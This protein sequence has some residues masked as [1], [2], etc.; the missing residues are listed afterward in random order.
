M[1]LFSKVHFPVKHSKQARV[2]FLEELNLNIFKT[3]CI[4][5]LPGVSSISFQIMGIVSFKKHDN[6]THFPQ[7][8]TAAHMIINCVQERY[9]SAPFPYLATL[10]RTG[11]WLSPISCNSVR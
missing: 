8:D 7:V 10:P 2:F 9:I 5:V 11:F 1:F 4:G 3:E 6:V